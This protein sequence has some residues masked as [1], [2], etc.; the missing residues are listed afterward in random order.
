MLGGFGFKLARWTNKRH[1]GDVQEKHVLTP[2]IAAHLPRGFHKWQGLDITNGT[3]DF[4]NNNVR[5]VINL[6]SVTHTRLNLVGDVRN[7][8]HR[9]TQVFA[10]AFFGDHRR[11]HLTG[12]HV[13][14]L[15]KV[16]VKETL[17][18]PDVE[19]GFRPI[20]SHEYLT[21]LERVHGSGV[22]V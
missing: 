20:I 1:Q 21:V 6:G 4:G 9:I 14:G 19:V 8:L 13:R 2:H 17:V 5:G 10:A 12:S 11:V 7:H 22:N 16:L 15:V 18:V 3:A